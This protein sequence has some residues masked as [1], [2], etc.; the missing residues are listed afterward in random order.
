MTPA[1]V[2]IFF[3]LTILFTKSILDVS[4]WTPAASIAY[5]LPV[6][7]QLYST[8]T[9]EGILF[10]L[11]FSIKIPTPETEVMLLPTTTNPLPSSFW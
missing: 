5:S 10:W 3:P 11:T 7:I 1:G 9:S 8:V 2:L 6:I 4:A